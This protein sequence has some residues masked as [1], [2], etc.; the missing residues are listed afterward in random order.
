MN[1]MSEAD[2]YIAHLLP[3]EVP[4]RGH[5]LLWTQKGSGTATTT[6]HAVGILPQRK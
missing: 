2:V 4:L 1:G 3:F 6:S 5:V